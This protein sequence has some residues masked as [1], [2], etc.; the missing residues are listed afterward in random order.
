MQPVVAPTPERLAMGLSRS[1][2]LATSFTPVIDDLLERDKINAEQHAKLTYYRQQALL[3]QKSPTRDSCDFSV[4]GGGG[5]PSMAILS[6][7]SE[8]YRLEAQMGPLRT[9]ARFI[10]VDDGTV[11]QWCIHRYGSVES[12]GRIRPVGEFKNMGRTYK[13]LESVADRIKVGA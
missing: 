7:M 4:R 12:G 2:G 8:T 5:K 11:R 10:A 9:L 13:E 6:A 3:A 1:A